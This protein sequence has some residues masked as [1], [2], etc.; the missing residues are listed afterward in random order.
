MSNSEL[1]TLKQMAS[2]GGKARAA[3]LSSKRRVE[4]A[5]K[6]SKA[7]KKCGKQLGRPKGSKNKSL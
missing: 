3:K 4:I 7:A 1:M 6:A 5:T 2:M